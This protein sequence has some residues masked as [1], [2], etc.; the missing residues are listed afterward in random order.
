MTAGSIIGG[1]GGAR[2]AKRVNPGFLHFFVVGV[3][4]LISTWFFVRLL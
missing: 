3:G 4:L 2:S 1:Y